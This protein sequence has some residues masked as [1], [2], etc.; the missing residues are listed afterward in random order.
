MGPADLHTIVNHFTI[1]L[2]NIGIIFELTAA[3]FKNERMQRFSWNSL[4]LGLA[5]AILS[6]LTGFITSSNVLIT[7]QVEPLNNYHKILSY[8]AVGILTFAVL[9]RTLKREQFEDRLS[10][11]GLRGA[12][13]ALVA[14][15]F[16]LT[17]VTGFLGTRMVYKYGV[18]VEPYERI[19]ESMPPPVTHPLPP[20]GTNDTLQR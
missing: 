17:G 8:V 15:V 2:I 18:N 11:A 14:V 16:F 19:L 12:Y 13:L 1:A 9:L 6:L 7:S 20:L 5:F 10:G 3:I 4:R